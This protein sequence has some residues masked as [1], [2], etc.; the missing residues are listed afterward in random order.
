MG[1]R[2]MSKTDFNEDIS[3]GRT[4]EEIFKEDYLDFL[5][6]KEKAEKNGGVYT[7]YG[8]DEIMIL[9]F[10]MFIKKYDIHCIPSNFSVKA[11]K[12][13]NKTY[14][15][16]FASFVK[17]WFKFPMLQ[18][19]EE[20]I[21]HIIA[22]KALAKSTIITDIYIN[23]LINNLIDFS[24][25]YKFND[26]F[27]GYNFDIMKSK[28]KE[29]LKKLMNYVLNNKNIN[30]DRD[31]EIIKIIMKEAQK[32]HSFIESDI[33]NNYVELINLD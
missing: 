24:K 16:N 15:I 29:E 25:K 17:P 5:K 18:W 19:S 7:T 27:K 10:I 22:K 33:N 11:E 23:T 28:G 9:T 20:N 6:F 1:Q 12:I 21:W 30:I 2:S 32:I 3:K 26:K 31:R 4:G 14:G 13:D 8:I